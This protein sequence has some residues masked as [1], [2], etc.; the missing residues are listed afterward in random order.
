MPRKPRRDSWRQVNGLWTRSLGSRGARVRLFER[1]K[2]GAY[3]RAVHVPGRG[4]DRKSL[5]TCD[6]DEAERLGKELL[7]ALLREEELTQNGVV[8][9]R[10]LADRYHAEAAAFLDNDPRTQREEQAHADVLLAFFG[11]GCNVRD[12]SEADVQ[13]FGAA[14]RNGGIRLKDGRVTKPVRARSVEVES[15]I[16]RTMLRWGTTVR[17]RG[18]ERLLSSNPLAGMR[19]TGEANPKRP[20]A[21]WERFTATRTAM[22]QL[23]ESNAGNPTKHQHWVRMELALVLAEAAGRR[24]GSIRKLAW[25]DMDA[26]TA[27]ILWRSE[28]DKKG[29]EWRVPC[30]VELFDEIRNFRVRLGGAFG[31]LVFPSPTDPEKPLGR[32]VLYRSLM[33]AERHAGL[34]KLDGGGWHTYRRKWGTER[35]HLPLVDVAAAGGWKGER[36]LSTIYQQPDLDTMLAVMSEPKKVSD[37]ATGT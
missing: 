35:K 8:T 32:E 5:G 10:Y 25:S 30:P 7:A 33:A 11:D 2:G 37:R 9:L 20:I 13:A 24:A 18:G 27:T 36:M 34:P 12:L 23:A 15:R 22:Q 1:T 28:N 19:G 31:G 16:L 29:K 4:K 6:R 3:Y 17:F 14:R 26:T 21:T